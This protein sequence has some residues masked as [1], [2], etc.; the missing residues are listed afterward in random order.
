MKYLNNIVKTKKHTCPTCEGKGKIIDYRDDMYESEIYCPMCHGDG[1]IDLPYTLE[2]EVTCDKCGGVGIVLDNS[3]EL[4]DN[5][6]PECNGSGKVPSELG[7]NLLS[8][9]KM[10]K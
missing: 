7:K 4:G 6:C 3:D 1:V 5:T 8:F 9:I 2:L 10:Y